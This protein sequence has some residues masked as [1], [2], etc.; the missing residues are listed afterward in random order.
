MAL[1]AKN[2]VGGNLPKLTYKNIE[3]GAVPARLVQVIDIG[4][5][6]DSFGKEEKSPKQ[7]LLFT[8]ELCDEFM[9]DETGKERK[10][11]PRWLSE[12]MPHYNITADK[13]KSTARYNAFDPAG[14]FDGDWEKCLGAPVMV[15]V[16]NNPGKGPN[17][18]RLFDNIDDVSAM[19]SK[20]AARTPELVNKPVLF[21][22][23]A[24][25][26]EVFMAFPKFIQNK[27]TSNLEFAGSTLEGMLKAAGGSMPASPPKT[28]K[29]DL[30][31][32]I[33]Y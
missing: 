21:D 27:I 32:E 33:P 15:T 23:S 20:M 3:P 6:P 11:Q 13:A 4:L 19:Q 26:L 8:Y 10:D 22:L 2:G 14:V 9:L 17:A 30:D 16:I 28:L 18:G 5:H 1:N 31:D 24:P 12:D 7:R 29:E 25:S